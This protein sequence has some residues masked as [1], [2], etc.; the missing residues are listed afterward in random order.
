MSFV[1]GLAPEALSLT[2]NDQHLM[3]LAKQLDMQEFEQFFINLGM[4]RADL[5][6]VE[7]RFIQNEILC[8]KLMALYRWKKKNYKV[9]LQDLLDGL[10]EIERSHY[11]CQVIND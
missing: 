7:H 6:E 1:I 8:R 9:S 10:K 5:E 11:L 2:P 3:R 4:K